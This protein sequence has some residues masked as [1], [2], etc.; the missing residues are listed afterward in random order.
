[1]IL[2]LTLVLDGHSDQ[3]SG[4]TVS[5]DIDGFYAL[6]DSSNHYPLMNQRSV[7]IKPGHTNL[8]GISATRITASHNLKKIPIDKRNCLFPDEHKL[9]LFKNYSKPSCD[10]E[11]SLDYAMSK[12]SSTISSKNYISC[13]L[14]CLDKQ[15]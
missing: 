3:I 6:I 15:I 9:K 4:G 11:C 1:M 14:L 2:G 12:V 7:L 13:F 10:F 5:G 8:I